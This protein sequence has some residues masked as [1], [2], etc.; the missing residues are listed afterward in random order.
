MQTL[1]HIGFT[2]KIIP[3]V[4]IVLIVNSIQAQTASPRKIG[5]PWPEWKL[6]DFQPK[7]P[8]H[9]QTYG[10]DQFRGRVTM[11]ALLATWCPFCQ[12]QIEKM[13]QLQK[14]LSNDRFEV[15]FVVINIQS[16]K[17]SQNEFISRCSFP[18]FQDTEE[19]DAFSKHQGGKDD[20]YI[21]NE[22]GEL[23]DHFPFLGERN[24]DL[25]DPK[26]YE[27]VKQALLKSPYK[28]KISVDTVIKITI[29]GVQGRTYRIQY[30][31]DLGQVKNW[32]S[33]KVITLDADQAEIIDTTG[34]QSRK[35]RFYR[36]VEIP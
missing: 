14:D 10:L 32:K 26:G 12:R 22:R 31:E 35:Q 21:Y 28:T 27:N 20:F 25:T 4:L 7:S 2:L 11:V 16:G 8:K 29:D 15:N 30:S 1:K 3:L 19:I 23:T 13:E 36:T 33:L 24:S 17:E 34:T 18:L 9:N 6:L 5:S